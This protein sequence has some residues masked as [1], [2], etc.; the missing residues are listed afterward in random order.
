MKMGKKPNR[1]VAEADDIV[2]HG[3]VVEV[4]DHTTP[5][6]RESNRLHDEIMKQARA[7]AEQIDEED[8]ATDGRKASTTA[9]VPPF[10]IVH[11]TDLNARQQ[12]LKNFHSAA[13][14]LAEYGFHSIRLGDDWN[15]ADF[16][17]VHV[18]GKQ[19]LRVQL[20][21]RLTIGRKYQNK[22][23]YMMFPVQDVWYLVDHD[24]L[25][26]FARDTT[27]W[28]STKSWTE[29][30]LYHS[31]APPSALLDALAAFRMGKVEL[32]T[33]QPSR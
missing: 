24:E 19:T 23:L 15:G 17:A 1:F 12:E 30:G 26:D 29:Q 21:A 9:D 8:D 13:A 22:N 28:L 4:V 7:I 27:N 20:K 18:N 33:F 6:Q 10:R 3:R 25:M 31:G 5:Q 2:M 14:V 11:Y 32:T 16:L